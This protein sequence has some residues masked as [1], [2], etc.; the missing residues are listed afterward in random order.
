MKMS[1]EHGTRQRAEQTKMLAEHYEDVGGT[2]H[3]TAGGADEDVGG[4]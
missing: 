1:A 4:M 2:W 3:T